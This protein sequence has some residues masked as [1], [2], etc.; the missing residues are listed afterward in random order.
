[1]RMP[2]DFTTSGWVIYNRGK[3]RNIS[4]GP[5]NDERAIEIVGDI[6]RDV[7]RLG[8]AD[9]TD[10]NNDH[11]FFAQFSFAAKNPGSGAIYFQLNSSGGLKYLVYTTAMTQQ[12]G[13]SDLIYINLG[14]VVNEQWY[15]VRRNLAEDLKSKFPTLDILQVKNLFVYGSLKL[16]NVM[17]LDFA[18]F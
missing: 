4:S 18:P 16:D 10:W 14:E 2:E 13:D 12:G 11:E 9:G 17:L 15:T 8:K 7:F 3:V 1:M 6:N 5:V